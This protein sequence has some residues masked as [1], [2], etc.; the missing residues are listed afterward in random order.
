MMRI[1]YLGVL[2]AAL[3]MACA[4]TAGTP[5]KTH[6]SDVITRDEIDASHA[7]NAYDAIQMLRPAFFHSHGIVSSNDTGLPNV[8]LNNQFYGDIQS[9]RQV[10]VGAIREI[11]HYNGPDATGRFGRGNAAGAIEV[12]TAPR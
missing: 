10:E 8:Y 3:A 1:K 9:L 6:D 12:I 4:P 7:S 2:T 11:H 5:G